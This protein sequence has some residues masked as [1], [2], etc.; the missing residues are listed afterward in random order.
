MSF[1]KTNWWTKAKR[2]GED[3]GVGFLVLGIALLILSAILSLFQSSEATWVL[4]ISLGA[5]SVGLGFVAMGMST[6]SDERYTAL[7]ERIDKNIM[8]IPL[9]FKDDLLKPGSQA[10]KEAIMD[11]SK[12]KAQARLENDKKKVGYYRGEIYQTEKGNW[13]IRWGGKYPL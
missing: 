7:F 6:K 3:S 9:M 8:Y 10:L 12:T 4:G 5:I 11:E 13:A 2:Q 1:V